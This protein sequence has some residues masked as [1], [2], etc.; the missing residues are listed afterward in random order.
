MFIVKNLNIQAFSC[1]NLSRK[2]GQYENIKI[3][4]Y[5]RRTETSTLLLEIRTTLL[6]S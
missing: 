6:K 2:D 5:G 4:F 1:K 3:A